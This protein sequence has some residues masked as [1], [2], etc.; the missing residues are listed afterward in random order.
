MKYILILLFLFS[1]YCFSENVLEQFIDKEEDKELVDFFFKMPEEGWL[2][3][4]EDSLKNLDEKSEA[5]FKKDSRGETTLYVEN[6]EGTAKITLFYKESPFYKP[7]DTTQPWK[8]EAVIIFN[9]KKSIEKHG[10]LLT[11]ITN[12]E[13]H[14]V[15]LKNKDFWAKDYLY[16]A[17]IIRNKKQP[18]MWHT[19]FFKKDKIPMLEILLEGL[20]CPPL[21]KLPNCIKEEQLYYE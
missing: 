19:I 20:A 1:T 6:V 14:E 2:D 11:N 21:N 12:D 16:Q 7:E 5:Y 18:I 10:Q 4:I 17:Y 9:S 8:V 13:L 15:F 3:F